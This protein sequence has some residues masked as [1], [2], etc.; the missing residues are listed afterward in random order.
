MRHVSSEA[1]IRDH[2]KKLEE[3]EEEAEKKKVA[4][5]DDTVEFFRKR[6]ALSG[7]GI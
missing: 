1:L 7:N 2:F 3:K 6:G 5:A 4:S